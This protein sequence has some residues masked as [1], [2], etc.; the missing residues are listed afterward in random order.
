MVKTCT[1]ER[2]GGTAATCTAAMNCVEQAMPF[3][4]FYAVSIAPSAERDPDIYKRI[5]D[6]FDQNVRA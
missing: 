6:C 4:D 3:S 1:D 5:S 2:P